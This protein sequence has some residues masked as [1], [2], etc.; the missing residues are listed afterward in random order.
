M[1]KLQRIDRDI[2]AHRAAFL[3]AYFAGRL[4]EADWH[5]AKINELLEERFETQR[6]SVRA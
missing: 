2:A 1:T 3:T 6:G 5:Q 4:D